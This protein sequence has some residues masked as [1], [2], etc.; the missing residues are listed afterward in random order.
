MKFPERLKK[1]LLEHIPLKLLALAL[2][3]GVAALCLAVL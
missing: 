1:L 2:G 3:F